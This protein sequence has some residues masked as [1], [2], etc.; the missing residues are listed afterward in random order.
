LRE[1][2]WSRLEPEECN[3]CKVVSILYV[4]HDYESGFV[5]GMLCH[6][7]NQRIGYIEKGIGKKGFSKL[8]LEMEVKLREYIS[9]PPLRKFRIPYRHRDLLDF[10]LKRIYLLGKEQDSRL[11]EF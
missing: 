3:C 1:K 2:N 9:H 5:R 11:D 7:C 6:T 10:I 4:D 8:S